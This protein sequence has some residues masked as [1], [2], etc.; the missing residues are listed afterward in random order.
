MKIDLKQIATAWAISFNPTESQKELAY[1]RLK[2]CGDCP[3]NTKT[4][5]NIPTCSACGCPISKKIYTDEFNPCP[6]KKWQ[7]VDDEY[8]DK[9]KIKVNTTII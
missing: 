2:V 6:I 5:L 9:S 8:F 4:W 1:Q 3:K 7:E